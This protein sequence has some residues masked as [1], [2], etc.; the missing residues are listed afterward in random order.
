MRQIVFLIMTFCSFQ[1]VASGAPDYMAEAA[2][3]A[4]KLVLEREVTFSPNTKLDSKAIA[5][6]GRHCD[7]SKVTKITG[8][9]VN[10]DGTFPANLS[11]VFIGLKEIV[12]LEGSG[13]LKNPKNGRPTVLFIKVALTTLPQAIYEQAGKAIVKKVFPQ[14][15]ATAFIKS[16][17]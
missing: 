2:R 4:K 11:T 14:R 5:E 9:F 1:T 7:A 3:Q 8:C 6:I 12:M 10:P 13:L 17:L 15:G 16:K